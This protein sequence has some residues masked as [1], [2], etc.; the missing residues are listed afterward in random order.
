[1]FLTPGLWRA[2]MKCNYGAENDGVEC[3]VFRW[4]MSRKAT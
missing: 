2:D 4:G 1:M 3:R